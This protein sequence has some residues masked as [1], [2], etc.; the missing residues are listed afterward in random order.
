[1]IRVQP[2]GGIARYVLCI[3]RRAS[4]HD[5]CIEM[6][7]KGDLDLADPVVRS[8]VELVLHWASSRSLAEGKE[9]KTEVA[10]ASPK[11]SEAS[12]WRSSHVEVPDIE[13]A[14]LFHQLSS[15]DVNS[16]QGR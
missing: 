16:K 13:G 11:K 5:D 8:L 9:G 10:C 14:I 15:V 6:R 12:T 3:Q 7:Y 2:S 4:S 1:M